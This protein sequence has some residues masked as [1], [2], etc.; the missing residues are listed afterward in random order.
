MRPTPHLKRMYSLAMLTFPSG[1]T[2]T[3][4]PSW[5]LSMH[6][7]TAGWKTPPPRT[8]GMHLPYMKNVEW[9]LLVKQMSWA[10]SAHRIRLVLHTY[11]RG[12][13]PAMIPV[14]VQRR[15]RCP[16]LY[17]P[18]NPGSS[19]HDSWLLIVIIGVPLGRDLMASIRTSLLCTFVLLS[20][21]TSR[22]VSGGNVKSWKFNSLD[23]IGRTVVNFLNK[24]SSTHR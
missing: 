11:L 14:L 20:Q 22:R 9:V 4:S 24:R 5:S 18:H 3:H 7:S 17:S 16:V 13:T 1:N 8:Q 12:S 21:T 10:A 2:C 23:R 19:K 15:L 6:A